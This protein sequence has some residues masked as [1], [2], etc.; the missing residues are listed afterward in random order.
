[1]LSSLALRLLSQCS[2]SSHGYFSPETILYRLWPASSSPISTDP[3]PLLSIDFLCG[4][5]SLPVFL[6]P[7]VFNWWLSLQP[8]A[9]AGSSCADFSTLKM[10]AICSSKTLVHIRSTWH[11]IIEN[12][13]LQNVI[14]FLWAFSCE[15]Q[16]K[17]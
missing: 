4:P 9:H 16:R 15:Q 7:G 2:L 5:L 6:Q 17:M 3:S 14:L 1:M 8:P 11:H 10:G 13:I 12:D